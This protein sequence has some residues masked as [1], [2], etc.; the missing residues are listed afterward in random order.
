MKNYL[1]VFSL[2]LIIY[3]SSSCYHSIYS[4]PYKEKAIKSVESKEY[5]KAIAFYRDHIAERLTNEDRPKWENPYIYL[6]DI[7]DLYLE[8]DM[9]D[10]ALATYMEAETKNVDKKYITDRLKLVAYW[11]EKRDEYFKAI[12]HL[13]KYRERDPLIFDLIADRLAKTVVAKEEEVDSET[14]VEKTNNP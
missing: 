12:D 14:V 6:L 7:G 5:D 13:N 2:L 4:S 8:Q 10:K 9:I 3:F 11:Y 1:K